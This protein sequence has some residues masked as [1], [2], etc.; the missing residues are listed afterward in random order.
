M[1]PDLGAYAFA[2]LGAYGIT[3]ASLGL[4]VL[5]SALR[6]AQ[7]RRA[8]ARLERETRTGRDGPSSRQGRERPSSRPSSGNPS[9]Q[10]GLND[11]A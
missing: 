11:S 7:V 2:V 6:G 4:L 5:V 9:A 8:L 3:L 10:E 1:I